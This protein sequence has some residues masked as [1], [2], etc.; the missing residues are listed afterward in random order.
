MNAVIEDVKKD[1]TKTGKD[2]YKVK[3]D[4]KVYTT[5]DEKVAREAFALKGKQASVDVEVKQ[6]G[7][8]TNY[9]LKGV[10]APAQLEIPSVAGEKDVQIARAVALKAAVDFQA[11][12]GSV[13]DVKLVAD[14]FLAWLAGKAP[15]V[16]K[17]VAPAGLLDE[18]DDLPF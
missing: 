3:I 6:S 7:E 10:A 14:E 13:A 17:D 2:I 16:A 8:Y 5:F 4:G 11:G 1:Q 15:V 12:K 18:A 9:N